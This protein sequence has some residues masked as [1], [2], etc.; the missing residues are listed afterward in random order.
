MTARELLQ[1]VAQF[2]WS[3]VEHAHGPAVDV[4]DL[5]RALAEGNKKA[6][7][8]AWYTLYG[9]LWHQGTIY[10]A[11]AQTVPYFCELLPLL[12]P[13]EQVR[14]LVYFVRL[15]NGQG[16]W[17]VHQSLTALPQPVDML[18]QIQQEQKVIA[19]TREA[20]TQGAP[21]YIE[22]L[23]AKQ[24]G[25]RIASAYLLGL[26]QLA[27]VGDKVVPEEIERSDSE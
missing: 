21:I 5:F 14:L 26:L 7:D 19:A 27:S 13:E 23:D 17:S 4:P 10:A 1:K 20:V 3:K 22:I 12:P 18:D 25:P 8:E 11:T 2:D 6:R 24:H 15:Y 16:Y 9:N